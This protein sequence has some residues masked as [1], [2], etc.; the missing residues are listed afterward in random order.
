MLTKCT[1]TAIAVLHDISFGD[2]LHT[3]N[4]PSS[5]E[6]WTELFD[7]LVSKRLIRCLPGQDKEL[8]SSYELCRPLYEI[9]LLDVLEAI[10]EP[11]NCTRPTSEEF[12]LHNYLVAQKVGVLNRVARMFLS[13][14]KISDRQ[15][16]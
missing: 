5:R 9:S 3:V 13:E 15:T 2:A 1:Q 7:N 6:V 11:I 10:G 16:L 14:I 8:L 4:F 12:Y